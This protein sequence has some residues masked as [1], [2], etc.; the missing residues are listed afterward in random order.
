MRFSLKP[1]NRTFCF[2][3]FCSFLATIGFGEQPNIVLIMADDLGYGDLGCYGS[4]LNDTP[5]IDNLAASGLR[6]T[7]FHSAGPMCTPTRVATMTGLYQ[8]RF[9]DEFDSAISGVRD[10]DSGLPL[11]AITIAE[12]LRDAGYATGC[13]GKWHLGYT[14]AFFPT[15]QGFDEFVGL[16]SG[17]GDFFNHIDR[18]GREDWWNGD[19]KFSENGYTTDLLTN[20]SVNFIEH[21]ADEPF[22]LYVP[23]LAIHFPWQGPNDPPH[24]VKGVD[25]ADD[26]WGVIPNRADV[27]PHVK[28]MIESLD[29][30]VGEI[31]SALKAHGLEENTLV[32]FTSDNGGY[33]R[34]SGG[35]EKISS[36]G[37]LRGQKTDV[38]EGGHRVPAI[39]SWPSRIASGV[40][41]ELGHSTDW[42]PTFLALA[43]ISNRGIQSDGVDLSPLIFSEEDLSERNLYWR[44]RDDY[45]VRSGPWKMTFERSKLE[46]FN[47]DQD[48]GESHD[49]SESMP[50]RVEAMKAAWMQ[51]N[52]NVDQ[53]AKEYK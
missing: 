24:R 27:S 17:D 12:I 36:N 21:H 20:H 28:A 40:T 2:V 46:L 32:V 19:R 34:Y 31:L 11:E 35:F 53:S 43:G 15:K 50:E 41:E 1:K 3:C 10:H 37:P 52:A 4:R 45:A 23:H 48:I 29:R 22:F 18:S 14:P 44:I 9:G 8:Q 42:F 7:D 49:L 6:F 16:G 26:K 33:V 25:Y 13:F 47:L 39:V 51:W 38:Y 30:S 5:H